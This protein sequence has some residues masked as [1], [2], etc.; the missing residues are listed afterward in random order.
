LGDS[1]ADLG[2]HADSLMPENAADLYFRDIPLENMEIRAADS[3]GDHLYDDVGWLFDL[4]IR[5]FVP[6]LLTRTFVYEGFHGGPPTVRLTRLCIP[7]DDGRTRL[8]SR[9][10]RLRKSRT[11]AELLI[12]CALVAG[13]DPPRLV[14]DVSNGIGP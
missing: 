1:F 4:W 10:Y 6:D 13:T 14:V 7:P 5:H 3:R 12:V 8:Y 9:G 11:R 2:D